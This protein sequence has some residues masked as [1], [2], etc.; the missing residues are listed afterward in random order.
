MSNLLENQQPVFITNIKRDNS[1]DVYYGYIRYTTDDMF[2]VDVKS[3]V[4]HAIIDQAFGP[5]YVPRMDSPSSCVWF[6]RMGRPRFFTEFFRTEAEVKRFLMKKRLLD[7]KISTEY[8][9]HLGN[10]R[11]L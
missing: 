4:N 5:I 3:L 2:Y 9:D 7:Y 10:L 11:Q 8:T 1:I 6:D